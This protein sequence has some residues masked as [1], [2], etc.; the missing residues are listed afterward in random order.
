MDHYPN[1]LSGGQQQRVAIAR[2]LITDPTII[3]ADEPTGDLDRTTAEEI[4]G[5]L[6]RLNRE[7]GKTIIMVTH[8]PEGGREGASA[9]SSR[10]GRARRDG[11]LPKTVQPAPCSSPP[12]R[13][14]NA[15]RHKLRTALTVVG[16][17]VAITAFGAAAHDRRRVVRG[18]QREL[19]R[20]ARDA[21]LGF[22]RVPAAAHLRGEDPTGPGVVSRC[23]GRTGSAAST[24]A[25][26][27]FFPQ[28][29]IDAPTY[30]DMYP[31]F[32]LPDAERKAFLLDRKGAIVGRKLAD[33][34]GWKVGDQIPLRGTIYPGTWTFKLRGIYDGADKGTD[35]STMFFHWDS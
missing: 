11:C 4:L 1:E 32:V 20:A 5:L 25:E 7:I 2:A 3:V 14:R 8:D 19:E 13:L 34:Y 21:Q 18:R 30:L 24:S 35:T 31:E 9:D 26:R 15:F 22:A 16:I 29:A 27:N 23:R 10:K 28:F 17:V 33:Q 6:D 12:A